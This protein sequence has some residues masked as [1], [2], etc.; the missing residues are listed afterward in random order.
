MIPTAGISGAFYKI[1]ND[2]ALFS[3]A[4]SNLAGQLDYLRNIEAGAQAYLDVNGTTSLGNV[5][6]LLEEKTSMPFGKT[7]SWPSTEV[8]AQ[9]LSEA[10]D[11]DAVIEHIK[12]NSSFQ[13]FKSYINEGSGQALDIVPYIRENGS[14]DEDKQTVSSVNIGVKMC[15]QSRDEFDAGFEAFKSWERSNMRDNFHP[16]EFDGDKK[17][18]LFSKD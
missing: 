1:R 15:A 2:D 11:A 13:A 9:Y 5:Q 10:V 3:K 17:F 14:S 7:Y 4:T 12:E 16:T 18:S 8:D 6:D